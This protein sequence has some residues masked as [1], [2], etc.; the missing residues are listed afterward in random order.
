MTDQEQTPDLFAE[1][2]DEFAVDPA[3]VTADPAA[4]APVD[5]LSDPDS[6]KGSTDDEAPAPVYNQNALRGIQAGPDPHPRTV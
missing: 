3:T 5:P 6:Y 4:D 2:Q 1:A